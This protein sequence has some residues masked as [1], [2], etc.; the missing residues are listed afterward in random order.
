[1]PV[2]CVGQCPC[3][4]S[5]CASEVQPAP[6]KAKLVIACLPRPS[7]TNL[8]LLHPNSL[9][10]PCSFASTYMIMSQRM[11]RPCKVHLETQRCC[12]STSKAHA[13]VLKNMTGR[14]CWSMACKGNQS[15]IILQHELCQFF[16]SA[17]MSNDA[18]GCCRSPQCKGH[19]GGSHRA[20][21]LQVHQKT[22]G[23]G[24]PG[25]PNTAC[26]GNRLACTPC[27]AL[28]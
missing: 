24:R 7:R 22:Q 1:M 23:K 26:G 27:P 21:P 3:C 13:K 20:D 8:V 18:V 10:L 5:K 2:H 14:C 17:L 16:C 28:H 12:Q 6:L 19:C 4:Q 25:G 9:W 15:L 11:K